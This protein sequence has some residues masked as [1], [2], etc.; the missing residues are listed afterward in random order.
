MLSSSSSR[1]LIEARASLS[2]KIETTWI[3]RQFVTNRDRQD[4]I[5]GR[6]HPFSALWFSSFFSSKGKES[7]SLRAHAEW[8]SRNALQKTDDLILEHE[9]AYPH[10]WRALRVRW[11]MI[12]RH[13]YISKP[14]SMRPHIPPSFHTENL[15]VFL[16]KEQRCL[17]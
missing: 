11:M 8:T 15:M 17:F 16:R 7:T 5:T 3:F 6:P 10:S 13:K 1:N 14:R 4:M 12:M 2:R 9:S